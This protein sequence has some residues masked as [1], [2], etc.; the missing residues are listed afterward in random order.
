LAYFRKYGSIINWKTLDNG[1]TFLLNFKDYDSID[2]IFLDKPHYLNQQPLL[3]RKCYNEYKA[4]LN[5]S[6]DNNLKEKI[7]NLQIS[8]NRTIDSDEFQLN[9][10]KKNI[11][12]KILVE[13]NRLSDIMKLYI[14]LERIKRDLKQDLIDT[15]QIN[16]QLKK[17]F[18][19]IIQKNKTIVEDF[20]N[21]LEQQRF[22]NKSLQESIVN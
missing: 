20:Q 19:Q 16:Q 5:Y 17:Q 22:I 4:S 21:Q 7:R 13:E 12:E 11:Q 3:I 14:R 6:I 18:Q 9:K 15:H 2:R 1:Q 8:I 10:L